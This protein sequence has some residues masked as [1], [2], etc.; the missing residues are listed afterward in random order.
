MKYLS[1]FL[2]ITLLG[3]NSKVKPQETSAQTTYFLIR[4]AEKDISNPENRNPELTEDG[5]RRAE[6]W[7]QI[8][9]EYDVDFVYSTDFI[10]TI[11][12][13]K[14][15]AENSKTE[16]IIYNPSTIYSDD[17]ITKTKGKTTLIVGHS[18]STPAL[19]NTIIG[20]DKYPQLDE[21]VYN[22]MYK[23]VIDGDK[24]EDFELSY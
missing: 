3:C 13:A 14:P 6:Q 9:D 5:I 2:L 21:S 22:K 19:V 20:K 8:L 7:A 24:I 17:F 18:N 1:L 15:T 10:R 12:T 4:H 16:I 23:V 11:E